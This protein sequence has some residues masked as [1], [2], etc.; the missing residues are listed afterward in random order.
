MFICLTL[1]KDVILELLVHFLVLYKGFWKQQW[2]ISILLLTHILHPTGKIW[3]L[4]F[5]SWSKA[6]T[7]KT[8][9]IQVIPTTFLTTPTVSGI[10]FS[11]EICFVERLL[12]SNSACRDPRVGKPA[13]RSVLR[14]AWSSQWEGRFHCSG[15]DNPKDASE[16]Q[17]KNYL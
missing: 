2:S 10:Q 8:D 11:Q 12:W 6:S 4:R 3:L 17:T 16:T 7:S 1:I 5:K 15:I 14:S 9:S 13:I